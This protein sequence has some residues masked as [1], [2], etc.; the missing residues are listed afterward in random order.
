M[1]SLR[2]ILLVLV[3]LGCRELAEG[4]AEAAPLLASLAAMGISLGFGLL[5]KASTL[6]VLAG[7]PQPLSP[8][9]WQRCAQARTNVERAWIAVLP[10]AL[11]ATG[12]GAALNG[13]Q[14]QGLPQA[15]SLLGWF[16]PSLF[17]IVLLELTA[18]QFDELYH[19]PPT[20][21]DTAHCGI[22]EL[23]EDS[24]ATTVSWQREW[25]LRLRLG[26]MASLVTCLT[27]VLAIAALTDA[28]SYFA[29]DVWMTRMILAATLLALLAVV[30][31][32]PVWLGRWMGVV[33]LPDG[34]LS[35]R[36]TRQMQALNIRGVRPK[37]VLSRGRW[38]GAAVVGWFPQFRQLWLGDALIE[39]LSSRQLDMV[40]MHELAHIKRRH[41]LWRIFP[42]VWAAS[43]VGLFGVFWPSDPAWEL[44]GTFISS[45]AASVVMLA[46]VGVMAHA[47]EL[48]ADVSAC[49][50][51]H[52]AC[53][54]AV[55]DSAAAARELGDALAE[56]MPASSSATEATWL[57]PNLGQRLHNLAR[58]S[59]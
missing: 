33:S 34:A 54:W 47:C 15:V 21:Q 44:S 50:L 37:L 45:I 30:L 26:D 9:C 2:L 22:P 20:P 32:L 46:G 40:V 19:Q 55:D 23:L 10:L 25:L 57:H 6:H 51:A 53:P 8:A 7:S 35:Q 13:L 43:V 1:I 31:F 49:V 39:R 27:P 36:V 28:A 42:V 14:E 38:P 29:N 12:W 3:T 18:A 17:L 4:N 56:L 41:F 16:L 52:Q 5:F 11:L 59:L 24:P 58:N 48:D